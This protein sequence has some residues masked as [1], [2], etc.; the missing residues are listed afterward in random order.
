MGSFKQK[1]NDMKTLVLLTALA[2]TGCASTEY[3]DYAKAQGDIARANADAQ[4]A[5]YTALSKVA[6]TGSESSR[7]AAVM[8]LALGTNTQGQAVQQV[9]APAPSQALQWAQVLVPSLT[10]IATIAVNA[11][12]A[13]NSADNAARVA[14]STNAT[15]AAI[16]SKIQA[17]VTVVPQAVNQVVAAP[18]LPQAN[19][20]T[21]TTSTDNH[22]VSNT[23]SS[24]TTNSM[25]NSNGVL[26][27]GS[28]S[29]TPTPVIVTPVVTTPP[30]V[31][32]P[33]VTPQVITPVVQIVPVNRP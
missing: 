12:V 26:G 14:E 8:A 17:P 7:I 29:V 10:N 5:R 18:V 15:F 28:Y 25:A 21:T 32:T 19:I 20:T 6:E 9:Q 1:R 16:A 3:A 22:A 27:S 13:A 4:T 24:A 30:V 2:L 11:K 23:T 33:S 31:I